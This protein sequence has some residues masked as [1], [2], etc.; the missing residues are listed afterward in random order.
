MWFVICA[1]LV[2]LG[3]SFGA[4]D[5][6]SAGRAIAA[7]PLSPLGGT[8]YAALNPARLLDTRPG[9]ATVDGLAAGAGAVGPGHTIN[10]GVL[11]RGGVP[12]T[13]VGSV[14]LHVTAVGQTVRGFVTVYP[15][16]IAL[17]GTSNLNPIPGTVTSNLVVVPVGSGGQVSLF[18]SDGDI[19]LIV[20][21]EGWFPIGSTFTGLTPTRVVDTRTTS[22]KV[23]A[24]E[25]LAVQLAGVAGVPAS[26][27]S[28]VVV[29]VTSVGA[30]AATFL[31]VHP[32]GAPFPATSNLNVQ[33]A[34]AGANL[35][36]TPLGADGKIKIYN[37]AGSVHVVVDVLG[38]FGAGPGFTPVPPARVADTRNGTPLGPN[39]T[40]VFQIAG[41]G[42]VPA[43]G[44][45]S[46]VFNL[47]AVRQTE[48]TYL[49]VFPTGSPQPLASDLNPQ[50]NVVAPNL[51]I[52]RLGPDGSVSVYNASGT[53]DI[54]IDVVGWLPSNVTAGDD[55]ITVT[56]DSAATAVPVLANDQDHD[57]RPLK[58]ASVTQPPHGTVAITGGGSGVTYL[59][60]ANFCNTQPAPVSVAP[61]DTFTYTLFG[62]VT[63]TVTVTVTCVD[64][65]P[66]AVDDAATLTEDDAA[67]TIPVLGNDTDV[68]GGP[69]SVLSVTQP[70][71]GAVAITGAGAALSY[72]PNANYCNAPP[73]APLD[74]FTYTLNGGSTATVAVTVNCVDDL[75][76]AVADAA[77][78]TEDSAAT[79]IPVLG[80]DTDVDSGPKTVISVT[81]P[82]HGSV[83]VTG[84]G[85]GL[86]YAPSAN[87]CNAAAAAT[88]ALVLPSLD[89]FTYTLNGGSVATVTMTVTCVDDAPLA[90]ADSATVAEDSSATTVNVLANDTDVDGGPKQVASVTQPSNGTVAILG[91]GLA[92]SYAPN[93]D[94]CNTSIGFDDTF[95]Y[96]LNGGSV[97]TVS[98]TVQC[99]NDVPSFVKGAD[100][101]VLEDAGAQSV[102]AWATAISKGPAN[103]S[104]QTVS[105][106]VTGNSNAALFSAGP[107]VAA[108][109]TLT[110]TPAANASGSAT[111]TLTVSDNGG[112]ANGGVDTS[113]PQTFVITVGALND[114]PSFVKGGD[115][116]VS[117]DAGAQ[118]VSGWATAIS[119][120]PANES[121][122]SVSFNV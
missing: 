60:P 52:G 64:D 51:V 62:G 61:L 82:T 70:V 26:G 32:S 41:N 98:V 89:T 72:T 18:N 76:V 39:A 106:N 117:E 87:Y 71:N 23:G 110:F 109:G 29:N 25:S 94:Y 83:V 96:T 4:A 19:H 78:V 103:E 54:I 97:A 38:W 43:A 6:G 63:A 31:T 101:S 24:G 84:G 8:G 12:A 73:G 90:V 108:D 116:T 35:V 85:S 69:K 77:T 68:D 122:Q 2:A 88:S 3:A 91:G 113:A 48:R 16:G 79:P 58:V 105:F 47:T 49:T 50:P 80:N 30:T 27:V 56:E 10:V 65:L 81:Q 100:Q 34:V 36:V 14:A 40:R 107:A 28:A 112:T 95:T 7:P 33:P 57:G 99:I 93:A 104:G 111:V 22:N 42:G 1:G 118:S 13:G 21:V 115:Q 5:A 102:A 119:P 120:G 44:A 9:V 75:P 67:T 86:T 53:V 15:T 74:T 55:S 45:G 92:V 59:P 121:G 37:D 114:A 66:L 46:V 20:D 11:G 17:P